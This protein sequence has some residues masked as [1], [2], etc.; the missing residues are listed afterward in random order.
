MIRSFLTS[1]WKQGGLQGATAS[2]A[3]SVECGLG[4]TMTSD[5][6]LLGFM[7][8]TVKVAI[9]HPAEFIVLSFQQQMATTG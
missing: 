2:E 3:F 9:V 1:I 4:T 6:L 8:V 5:D 7:R